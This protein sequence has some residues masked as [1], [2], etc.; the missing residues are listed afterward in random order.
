MLNAS[1]RGSPAHSESSRPFI[2]R[3][4]SAS[5]FVWDANHAAFS[6]VGPRSC[7]LVSGPPSRSLRRRSASELVC[8]TFM[9]PFSLPPPP[10][11]R[12][13]RR[14]SIFLSLHRL[15]ACVRYLYAPFFLSSPLSRASSFLRARPP[16][17]RRRRVFKPVRITFARSSLSLYF[18]ASPFVQLRAG[19]NYLRAAFLLPPSFAVFPSSY[20]PHRHATSKLVCVTLAQPFC[21]SSSVPLAPSS[22]SSRSSS[23]FRPC[24][25]AAIRS[26]GY[27]RAIR[28]FVDRCT[29]E[30]GRIAT[31][32][33]L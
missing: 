19:L 6:A 26:T 18:C 21:L 29:P 12:F 27:A 24:L 25:G 9:C 10:R 14:G 3:P 2:G 23:P 11:A 20:L 31:S 7:V 33:I 13:F 16:S 28:R 32:G 5:S 22:P 8:A 30:T 4:S 1:R 17:L 15:R